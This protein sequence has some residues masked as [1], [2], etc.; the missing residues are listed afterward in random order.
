MNHRRRISKEYEEPYKD[1]ITGLI[2]QGCSVSDMANTLEIDRH[3]LA[4]DCKRLN[5][6][7]N[8]KSALNSHCRGYGV[9][10]EHNHNLNKR[11]SLVYNGIVYHPCEPTNFFLYETTTYYQRKMMFI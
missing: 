6:S 9:K 2:A 1:V 10:R 4:S 5:I 3:T 8:G 7:T 11:R